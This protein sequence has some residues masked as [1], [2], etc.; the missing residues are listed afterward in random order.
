MGLNT[1]LPPASLKG[2]PLGKRRQWAVSSSSDHDETDSPSNSSDTIPTTT[3]RPPTAKRARVDASLTATA[4]ATATTRRK[5]VR[6]ESDDRLEQVRIVPFFYCMTEDNHDDNG[7]SSCSTAAKA[8]DDDI[9]YLKSTLWWTRDERRDTVER[10]QLQ[11]RAVLGQRAVAVLQAQAVYQQICDEDD[12]YY[13]SCR[14]CPPSSSP[15]SSSSSSL[16]SDSDDDDSDS[17]SDESLET[18]LQD[19]QEPHQ[20][21]DDDDNDDDDD[22]QIVQEGHCQMRTTPLPSQVRGLEWATIPSSK[23][24][25]KTHVRSVLDWQRQLLLSSRGNTN[26]E[27]TSILQQRARASSRRSRLMARILA[28]GDA[29]AAVDNP[30]APPSPPLAVYHKPR[31]PMTNT[32]TAGRPRLLSNYARRPLMAPPAPTPSQLLPQPQQRLNRPRMILW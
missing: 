8:S 7:V 16:S 28:E 32:S 13:S 20:E 22:D 27:P 30:G 4:T 17:D 2:S 29:A 19:P 21:E 5:T 26:I 1:L 25:R 18:S 9:D 31:L 24:H 15:V 11:S 14:H 23:A 10:N 12:E 3:T 6:F